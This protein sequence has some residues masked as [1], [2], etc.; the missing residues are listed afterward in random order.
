MG[1]AGAAHGD[2]DPRVLGSVQ[3][4]LI[5]LPI[6]MLGGGGKY[7]GEDLAFEE[8]AHGATFHVCDLIARLQLGSNEFPIDCDDA[9]AALN[10]P[11]EQCRA[12]DRAAQRPGYPY[13]RV[14]VPQLC[15]AFLEQPIVSLGRL[16]GA[17]LIYTTE[18]KIFR[19]SFRPTKE[20]RNLL[21]FAVD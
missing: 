12:V 7:V 21:E 4:S 18:T 14:A 11:N 3:Q 20:W 8:L 15:D 5:G 9:R 19:T 17:F 2:G 16:I 1:T 13:A 10:G 6:A